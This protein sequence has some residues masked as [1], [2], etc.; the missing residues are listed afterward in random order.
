MW[1]W[2]KITP[3]TNAVLLIAFFVTNAIFIWVQLANPGWLIINA[4]YAVVYIWCDI[5]VEEQ[6]RKEL[7]MEINRKIEELEVAAHKAESA[8]HARLEFLSRMSHD[9]RTPMNA[10]IGLTHLARDEEDLQVVREY[11]HNI[12]TSSTFLLG[13]INDIL[14]MSK[15]ENGEL[16]LKE[17]SF[18]KQEFEDSINTVIRPL[19]E[20]KDIH[21]VFRLSDQITC[22]RA[23][24]LRF[25]QIFF[26]L[27]SNAAKFTPTGGTVEF[28]SESLEPRGEK[29]GIRFTIR[30]NGVGM[31]QEFMD[32]MY[33][34]FSQE[35]SALGDTARGTGL[36]LPIVKSLVD[37]MGGEISV[38]SQLGRGTE[39]TVE[40]YVPVE[41]EEE[42]EPEEEKDTSIEK[43]KGDRILL[44]EDNE[45]NIYVAQ[46]IL[47]KVGCIVT[48]ARNGEEA[49]KLF[50][51]SEIYQ[52]DAILMDVRM[53]IMNGLDATRA[54]RR[55]DRP[56][57]PEV[58]IIAMTADAFDEERRN[59]LEAGMDYHLSKPI[60]PPILYKVLT[61][62][63]Q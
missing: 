16:T 6:R 58:P 50:Q 51:E 49:V 11:L 40:L 62:Y 15:I 10:I 28:L 7:Y 60:N 45:I 26:N 3:Q 47:E 33:D 2:Q 35:R 41:E 9:I 56:D 14:D 31:S 55:M 63:I 1:N 24:R 30:D 17:G 4:S 5:T 38:T 43:L 46:I 54:I 34:P 48:V 53:P 29:A 42:Q 20:E 52:F 23:D 27:L 18:T 57:A 59:T 8:A 22:I 13:L 32:H 44:V 39:F 37:A 19:M 36:G 21:F 12:D 25:S 61:E